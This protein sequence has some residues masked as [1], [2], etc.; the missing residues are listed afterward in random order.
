MADASSTR[1]GGDRRPP[2]RRVW[3][4]PGGPVLIEGPVEFVMEDGNIV[5]SDRPMVAVCTCRRSR[6]RP[7]CDTSHRDRRRPTAESGERGAQ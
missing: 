3:Q 4:E 2:A 7:W 1:E 5:R 6:I